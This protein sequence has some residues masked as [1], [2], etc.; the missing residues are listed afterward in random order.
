MKNSNAAPSSV[1]AD[2]QL[3]EPHRELSA[4]PCR[5]CGKA[6]WVACYEP[7]HP[8]RAI[9]VECCGEGPEHHD[10]ETGHGFD[11]DPTERDRVCRYCGQFAAITDYYD[12]WDEP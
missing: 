3:S 11:Y 10:G 4:P 8:E 9:C 2:D 12:H 1:C 5:V 6:E 7:E